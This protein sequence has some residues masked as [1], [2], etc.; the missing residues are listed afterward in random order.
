[1]ILLAVL[2][3]PHVQISSA[4]S[5]PDIG[6][7]FGPSNVQPISE[8]IPIYT[9]GDNMWVQSYYNSTIIL[10][11]LNPNG[12][13]LATSAVAEPGELFEMYSFTAKDVSGEWILTFATSNGTE[14]IPVLVSSSNSSLAPLYQGVKLAGNL[15]NQT[16]DFPPTDAYNIQVCS[17][18][19]S[20]TPTTIFVLAGGSNGTA[21]V[22]LGQNSSQFQVLGTPS[23]ASF[24]LELYSEYSYS[25]PG[26]GIVSQNLLVGNSPVLSFS[27]PGGVQSGQLALQMP[28]RE[29]RFDLRIFERTA[30]GLFLHDSQFLRELSGQWI[31]LGGCTIVEDV[32]SPTFTLTTNLDSFNSSWPRDLFTMYDI[33]GQ[34]SYSIS[35]VPGKEAAIHLKSFPD[36]NPLTGVG[37]T[38][39]ASGL[40]ASDWD[41]HAS[42][43]YVLTSG[44]EE[45]I[46]IR[47][48]YSGVVTQ[49]F[50]VSIAGLYTSKSVSIPAGTLDA[51]ATLQGK[52]L[53]NATISVAAPGSPPTVVTPGTSGILSILLPPNNYTLS[54]SYQGTSQKEAVPVTAGHVT[55]ANLDLTQASLPVLLYALA[56][57]GV[58]GVI[59][60]VL[61]WRQYIERRKVYS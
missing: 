9:Q 22:T 50:N 6:L 18:G 54:A 60:N 36:G 17:S 51:S 21:E 1:L 12:V 5:A 25:V 32:E 8:G 49:T 3:L 58:A 27:P 14:D 26:G 33:N 11:L 7:G 29:G 38:A 48:S 2:F 44:L 47:L 56:A 34:E 42:S 19:E 16:F 20:V 41:A 13:T 31:S 10:E 28:L 40:Q 61:I 53:T 37:I 23:Q 30:A 43:V 59:L 35:P 39:S 45:E 24:W 4:A 57:V 15:L 55:T 46:S 52:A